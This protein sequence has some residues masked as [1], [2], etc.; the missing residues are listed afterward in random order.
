MRK[1]EIVEIRENNFII[2][3]EK[4]YL[5]SR[6]YFF[7]EVERFI[8]ENERIYKGKK[9]VLVY[10]V[11]LGYYII[12]LLEVLDDDC[13]LYVFDCDSEIIKKCYEVGLLKGIESD[14]R[15]E[16]FLGYSK[17]IFDKF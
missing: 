4:I 7:K 10:G 6:Y 15:V 1:I 3:V 13:K 17:K 8:V 11:V 14:N 9:Y 2:C 12:K 5:Y 16:V